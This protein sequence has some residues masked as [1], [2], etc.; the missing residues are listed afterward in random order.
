MQHKIRLKN[1]MSI[2][3]VRKARSKVTC[4]APQQRVVSAFAAAIPPAQKAFRS[5]CGECLSNVSQ[6]LKDKIVTE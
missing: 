2:I 3:N 4:Y 5:S 1:R 6:A